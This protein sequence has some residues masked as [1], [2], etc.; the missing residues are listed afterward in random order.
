MYFQNLG[1][2]EKQILLTN[3]TTKYLKLSMRTN[4]VLLPW[5]KFKSKHKITTK[6]TL[7][8]KLI[9]IL[10]RKCDQ[11]EMQN[12]QD[13]CRITLQIQNKYSVWIVEMIFTPVMCPNNVVNKQLE[14]VVKLELE[15]ESNEETDEDDLVDS[16]LDDSWTI[17]TRLRDKSLNH[18]N[19]F[20]NNYL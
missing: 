18:W 13:T 7:P 2:S 11:K 1:Q 19:D 20:V 12:F 3:L 15:V 16:Q 9:L 10:Q 5:R 14:Q 4:L 6:N 8:L 17:S